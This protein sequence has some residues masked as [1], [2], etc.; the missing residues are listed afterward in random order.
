VALLSPTELNGFEMLITRNANLLHSRKGHSKSCPAAA[1]SVSCSLIVP[2]DSKI[3]VESE[4]GTNG[5]GRER[6]VSRV[7]CPLRDGDHLSGMQVARHL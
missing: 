4:F 7:L 3:R 2:S 6:R 5:V 1:F